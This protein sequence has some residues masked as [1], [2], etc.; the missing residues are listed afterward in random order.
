MAD[1]SKDTAAMA[2]AYQ[3]IANSLGLALNAATRLLD[4]LLNN[5][6]TQEFARMFMTI[7]KDPNHTKED[8]MVGRDISPELIPIVT[9][10]LDREN[11]IAAKIV[12]MNPD[13]EPS[14]NILLYFEC[15]KE[16]IDLIVSEAFAR[17]GLLKEMD[18]SRSDEF[19]GKLF[20]NP[21]REVKGLTQEK[22]DEFLSD[23]SKLKYPLNMITLFPRHYDWN[24]ISLVDVGFLESTTERKIRT[25]DGKVTESGPYSIPNIIKGLL[26]KQQILDNAKNLNEHG[27]FYNRRLE[28]RKSVIHK[29]LNLEDIK[30]ERRSISNI[31][32]FIERFDPDSDNKNMLIKLLKDSAVSKESRFRLIDEISKLSTDELMKEKIL[33][34]INDLKDINYLIPAKIVQDGMDYSYE[35]DFNNYIKVGA[36]VNIHTNR[37]NRIIDLKCSEQEIDYFAKLNMSSDNKTLLILNQNEFEQKKRNGKNKQYRNTDLEFTN[38]G[39]EKMSS[40]YKELISIQHDSE[41]IINVISSNKDSFLLNPTRYDE[42]DLADDAVFPEIVDDLIYD[43]LNGIIEKKIISDA[44]ENVKQDYEFENVKDPSYLNKAIDEARYEVME[45]KGRD[46][47]NQHNNRFGFEANHYEELPDDYWDRNKDGIDD[48]NQ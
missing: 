18:R 34:K 48:R 13:D 1:I 19:V 7:N 30:R 5:K 23:V 29:V 21:M 14:K 3:V 41:Q 37:C 47:Q 12:H 38:I 39:E 46:K 36:S 40:L 45:D 20:D 27:E 8:K 10:I 15:Q 44:L 42:L 16:K 4:G 17:T 33:N 43:N 32:S 24:G 22:Y 11:E 25:P 26:V 28:Y 31:Y 6:D 35:L 9:K 2:E